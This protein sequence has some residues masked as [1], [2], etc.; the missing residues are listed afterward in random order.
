M[1]ASKRYLPGEQSVVDRWSLGH[2]SVGVLYGVTKM[3]WWVALGLA[4]VWEVVENPLKDEF[5]DFFPDA[6]HDS[7]PR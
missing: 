1:S 6:K 4:V 5:P 2:A 3:P 7:I